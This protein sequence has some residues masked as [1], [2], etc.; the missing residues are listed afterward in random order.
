LT[1]RPQRYEVIIIGGGPA[2]LSAGIYTS[3]ARLNSLLIDKGLIGGQIVNA[4]WLDNY[5]GFPEGIS[6]TKLTELMHE[7]ATKYG[8][9]TIIAE[10]TGVRLQKGLKVVETSNGSFKAQVIII[11]GGCHRQKLGVPGEDEFTGKGVSYCATCDGAFFRELPIAVVGG[12][13][14][15]VTEALHLTKFATKVT[16]IHRRDQL[17]A[18]KILQEKAFSEPKIDFRWDSVVEKIEGKDLVSGLRLRNVKTGQKST[19][20]VSGVFVSIGFI[21]NTEYLKGVLPLAENG[22][23]ITNGMME[24]EVAGI[25]AAGDIRQ[26]SPRQVTT[27]CGDGATAAIQATKFLT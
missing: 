3:R 27:A 15:A 23:I 24:T 10:V 9:K 6:G 14:A 8:L 18:T 16:V 26:G 21:P 20:S 22:A 11:A 4:E 25:Y 7:Q 19:L 1:K 5:P 13:N 2:G 12:G 17:R